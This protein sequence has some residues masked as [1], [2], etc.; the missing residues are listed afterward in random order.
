MQSQ[1]EQPG[2]AAERSGTSQG[3]A[4][5]NKFNIFP[6]RTVSIDT[7][8]ADVKQQSIKL[9]QCAVALSR[10]LTHGATLASA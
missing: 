7:E 8:S 2:Y 4:L 5:L 6:R 1:S 3:T 9:R 10:E